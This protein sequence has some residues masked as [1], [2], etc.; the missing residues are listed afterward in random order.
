MP[1]P[2]DAPEPVR[3]VLAEFAALPPTDRVTLLIEYGD[4]LPSLPE[5]Y[6]DPAASMERVTECQ[7]PVYLAV[8]ASADRPGGVDLFVSAPAQ[9]PVTRGFAG[10]LHEL[11]GQLDATQVAALPLDLPDHLGLD[12]AISPLRLRAMSG[13]LARV[14]R[15]TAAAHR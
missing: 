13:L 6:A 1:L 5:R 7:S 12:A 9:A 3:A 4:E 14:T 15:A 11:T 10:L 2:T 8:T